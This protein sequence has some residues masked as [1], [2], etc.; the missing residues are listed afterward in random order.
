MRSPS[1][2]LVAL[3]G[4]SV[5][6]VAMLQPAAKAPPVGVK[7]LHA[8]S[9]PVTTAPEAIRV[10]RGRDELPRGFFYVSDHGGAGGSP[11]YK[12]FAVPGYPTKAQAHLVIAGMAPEPPVAV[13]GRQAEALRAEYRRR[14]SELGANALF[15]TD[16]GS[17]VAYAIVIG[18]GTPAVDDTPADALIKARLGAV[19]GY[20]PLGA[21]AP[22]SLA[23]AEWDLTTKEAHCY[24][25]IFAF[26]PG[27]TLSDDAE[28]ALYLELLSSDGL[29]GNRSYGGPKEEIADADGFA[30]EAPAHGRFV[31]LRSHAAELGCA[32]GATTA[33]LRLWTRGKVTSIGTGTLRVAMFERTISKKE[34][35]EKVR[36]YDAAMAQARAEAERQRQEDARREAERERE[37]EREE[38]ERAERERMEARQGGSTGGGGGSSYFSLT[39]KNE[40]PRTVKL[41]IGDKP[42]WGSGTSTSVS[43]NSINSYSGTAPQMYWIVDDSDNGLSAY[44]ATPGSQRVRILPSC[45]GFAPD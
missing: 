7:Q 20:K 29:L 31:A 30:I 1:L 38:R 12:L 44:T 40:C 19:K 8:G 32:K 28:R 24:A 13:W 21:A 41:F 36:E 39:L 37:R 4:S 43:S 3:L 23:T 14:A 26:E 11:R 45:T 34:L 2:A 10:L 6:C 22:I 42:K 9:L 27:A 16:D 18:A 15:E 33:R 17:N 25:A 35:A 5:G